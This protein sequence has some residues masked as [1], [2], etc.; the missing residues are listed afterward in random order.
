MDTI[1][2]SHRILLTSS[3]ISLHHTIILTDFFAFVIKVGFLNNHFFATFWL[4]F[5]VFGSIRFLELILSFFWQHVYFWAGDWG[6]LGPLTVLYTALRTNIV[7]ILAEEG[8]I[9]WICLVSLSTVV[10]VGEVLLEG[11]TEFEDAV[12]PFNGRCA[13]LMR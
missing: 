6:A 13:A 10:K 5:S 12:T 11:R 1:E 8:I 7:F 4:C 3:R 2:A 9:S